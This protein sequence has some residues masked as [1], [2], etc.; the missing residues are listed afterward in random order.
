MIIPLITAPAPAV[1]QVKYLKLGLKFGADPILRRKQA[2]FVA[3]NV[4]RYVMVIKLAI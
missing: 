4:I 2:R 1:H 3:R